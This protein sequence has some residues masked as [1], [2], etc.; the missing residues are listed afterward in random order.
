[1]IATRAGSD[2]S[3]RSLRGADL[4][5]LPAGD[6]VEVGQDSLRGH[7]AA[8][9]I[10]AHRKHAPL[11]FEGIDALLA[12]R[13]CL[14]YPTRLVFEFGEM[15]GHQF[16]E[17]GPDLRNPEQN[18]R[19]LYLR[20]LLRQRPELALLAVAY[21]IPVINYGDVIADEHCVR[22]G[23]TLLGMLEAEFYDAVCRLADFVGAEAKTQ[24]R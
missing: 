14:R 12:D 24:P 2:R 13:E 11:A 20:P 3:D 17:P 9:A 5:R 6:L 10:V 21:M 8:Q 18:G 16:A 15:A 7:I 23:A 22:Y 19:V 1:M 4:R